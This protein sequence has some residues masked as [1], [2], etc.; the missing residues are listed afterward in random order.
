MIG[1]SLLLGVGQGYAQEKAP[2]EVIF[3]CQNKKGD[4]NITLFRQG[5]N[6]IY[7]YGSNMRSPDLHLVQPENKVKK[8]PWNGVGN[9]FWSS[10]T[11]MNL[12]YAYTIHSAYPRGERGQTTAG[13][14]VSKGS[15]QIATV[16]CKTDEE[17]VDRLSSFVE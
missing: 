11:L 5:T 4:K 14:Q 12:E 9:E 8:Q 1:L 10:I 6:I 7:Q 13:V 2:I 17:F 15:K 3:W 16:E